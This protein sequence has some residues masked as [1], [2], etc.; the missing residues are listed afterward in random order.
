MLYGP[1]ITCRRLYI[2]YFKLYAI[3]TLYRR[4]GSL[5]LCGL[6]GPALGLRPGAPMERSLHRKCKDKTP[7]MRNPEDESSAVLML[8]DD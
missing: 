4:L 2:L 3:Y 6:R 1:C 5:F 7:K 8:E